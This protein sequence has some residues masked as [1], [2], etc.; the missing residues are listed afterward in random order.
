MPV[1]GCK[2]GT[3]QQSERPGAEQWVPEGADIEQLREAAPACRGC[4][5]WEPA[6]Q[7]V[8]SAGNTHARLVLV[9]E[10][11]GDVEDRVGE[12]FV[13]PA[14]KLLGRALEDAGIAREDVYVTNAVKHFR[15]TQRGK[16]RIHRKPDLVHLVACKPWLT[17]ELTDVDPEL[18]VVLGATAARSLLG[19]GVKVTQQ[20]GEILVRETPT[21][22]RR[23]LPTVHPSSVL[24]AR[25]DRD[26]AYQGLVADLRVAAHAL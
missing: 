11:P 1:L 8:F 18:T 13:G 3:V 5:L 15:F 26:A 20:R 19:P 12:P 4:E 24:R 23:F 7:V 25:G 22:E 14:G 2:S 16:R 21:G 6:S 17:A 9:G 10:Q